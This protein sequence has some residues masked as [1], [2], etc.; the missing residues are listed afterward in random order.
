MK[1]GL[2]SIMIEPP[3]RNKVLEFFIESRELDFGFGDVAKSINMNKTTCWTAFKSLEK[4]KYIIKSR[5]LCNKQLWK[6]NQKEDNV[7]LFI[8]LFN[9]KMKLELMNNGRAR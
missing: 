6:L 7:K 5:K 8:D 2:F 3:P 4:V 1:T 9:A